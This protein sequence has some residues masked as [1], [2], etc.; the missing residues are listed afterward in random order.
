MKKACY[1][2]LKDKNHIFPQKE[3]N[4]ITEKLSVAQHVPFGACTKRT[5]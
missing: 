2:T 5:D 4:L 3:W 1:T